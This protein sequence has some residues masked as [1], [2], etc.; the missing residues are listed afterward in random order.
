MAFSLMI[1][2]GLGIGA[3][4]VSGLSVCMYAG[5]KL[6][7]GEEEGG[8]V[9]RSENPESRGLRGTNDQRADHRRKGLKKFQFENE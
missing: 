2:K 5:T 8:K 7:R 9:G 3:C 4:Q 1:K 6:E